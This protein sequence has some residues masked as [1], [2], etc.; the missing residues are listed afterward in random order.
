MQ[1]LLLLLLILLLLLL[2][3]LAC[4]LSYIAERVTKQHLKRYNTHKSKYPH[5]PET[6]TTLAATSS[7]LLTTTTQVPVLGP[8]FYCSVE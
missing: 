3:H 2:L 1:F 7:L 8:N 4:I 5:H 6:L